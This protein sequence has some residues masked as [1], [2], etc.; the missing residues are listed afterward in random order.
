M[1]MSNAERQK[2]FREKQKIKGK[3]QSLI[4]ITKRGFDPLES[5]GWNTI[6]EKQ[7]IAKIKKAVAG[8]DGEEVIKE[9]LY[10]E[11]AAYAQKLA[12]WSLIQRRTR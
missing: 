4:W 1:A 3:I 6:T 5:G 12:K 7:M 10:A 2:K 8:F 9:V 11:V